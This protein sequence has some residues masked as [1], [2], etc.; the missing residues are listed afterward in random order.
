MSRLGGFPVI[1]ESSMAW[2]QC[3]S[4]GE[5]FRP[6]AQVP[7]QVYC[8]AAACQRERR[9]RWQSAKRRGDED[10]RDNQRRAQQTWASGR[11]EYWRAWR[12][13]HPEYVERNR[14]AAR[15]RQRARRGEASAF[16]KMDAS[17]ASLG[18]ASG[19]YRLVPAA[20]GMFAKM[21]AWTVEITVL[22]RASA[23]DGASS[24]SLQREDVIGAPDRAD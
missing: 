3:A 15:E 10:Y 23:V 20:G 8:G 4:C 18:V 1:G 24:G 11:A 19:T 22:S 12:L 16:A 6:R 17:R 13:R 5:R 9:R 14:V 21:D 7:R 2:R